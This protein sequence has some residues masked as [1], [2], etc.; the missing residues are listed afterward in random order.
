MT[1]YSRATLRQWCL[2][3]DGA[4]EDHP[5]GE[6]VFKVRQK[7]FVFTGSGD[8]PASVT[9]KVTPEWREVLLAEEDGCAFVPTYVGRFGWVG[10]HLTDEKAWQLAQDLIPLS[11]QLVSRRPSARRPQS[12]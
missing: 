12:S 4:W 11:Y 8:P 6:S 10:L 3:L 7:I 1:P 5:W 2:A 9:L